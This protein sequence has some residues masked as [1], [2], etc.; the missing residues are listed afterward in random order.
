MK[1]GPFIVLK[2]GQANLLT[3]W[4]ISWNQSS[5]CNKPMF[6]RQQK[7]AKHKSLTHIHRLL[8][9]DNRMGF[10]SQRRRMCLRR[11]I[12]DCSNIH[13][14]NGKAPIDMNYKGWTLHLLEHHKGLQ[15]RPSVSFVPKKCIEAHDLLLVTEVHTFDYIMNAHTQNNHI[16]LGQEMG[17]FIFH[18]S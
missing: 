15:T 18:T 4:V 1:N 7:Q 14:N 11:I 8:C 3:M 10:G 16:T 2:E 6:W 13:W 17:L 9:P 12:R 5:S